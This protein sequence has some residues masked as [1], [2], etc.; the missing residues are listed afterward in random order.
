MRPVPCRTQSLD[1]VQW[2]FDQGFSKMRIEPTYQD[3]QC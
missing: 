3:G 2:S 1:E